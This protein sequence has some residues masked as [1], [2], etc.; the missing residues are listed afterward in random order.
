MN[1]PKGFGNFQY[2][3]GLGFIEPSVQDERSRAAPLGRGLRGEDSVMMISG[4]ND[5]NPQPLPPVQA[6]APAPMQ[7]MQSITDSLPWWGW[8]LIGVLLGM[9]LGHRKAIASFDEED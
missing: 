8:L 6:P 4:L 3:P 1:M 2:V 7:T 9:F 5:V